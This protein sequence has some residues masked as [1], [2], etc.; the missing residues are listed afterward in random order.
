MGLFLV[1]CIGGMLGYL[2][3][4]HLYDRNRRDMKAVANN[5]ANSAIRFYSN[6]MD[7]VKKA[8]EFTLF[9]SVPRMKKE[10]AEG[11]VEVI[12]EGRDVES[13]VDRLSRETKIKLKKIQKN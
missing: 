5:I 2:V 6:D 7:I 12:F 11:L 13:F 10:Y 9:N 3:A 8:T 4:E 1:F